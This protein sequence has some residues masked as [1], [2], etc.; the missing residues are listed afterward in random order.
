MC[1]SKEIKRPF[2]GIT[3]G[4]ACH[5][6]NMSIWKSKRVKKPQARLRYLNWIFNFNTK[7]KTTTI[8]TLKVLLIKL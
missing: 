3:K 1:G 6:I 4:H 5:K 2:A 8:L 7:K